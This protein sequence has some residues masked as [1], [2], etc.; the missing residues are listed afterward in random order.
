MQSQTVIINFTGGI[1]SPGYLK[2]ILDAAQAARVSH[3]RFGLRQQLIMEVPGHFY[4]TFR[5]VC[6]EKGIIAYKIKEALPNIV[7]SYPAADIFTTDSWMREGVYKDI[8]NSFHHVPQLKINICDGRQSF[9]PF[10][11]GHINWVSSQS[12]HFWHLYIRFPKT[13]NV[14]RWKEQVYTNDIPMLSHTIE[15]EILQEKDLYF[16][17]EKADGNTLFQRVKGSTSYIAKEAATESFPDFSLPYYEGFNKLNNQL[18]LGIYRRDEAF[19]VPFLADV[20]NLCTQT[21]IGQLYT[22]PW[23]SIIIKNIDSAQRK[24]WDIVLGRFRINVRHAAN[25]L[26]WQVE[27]YTDKGLQLKGQIIRY[28]DKEDVRTYGLCFAV[29]TKPTSSMFGSVVIRKQQ[30]KNPHRLKALER[31]D[32]LYKKDFN[33]NAEE[34][35]LFRD[36]VQKDH[37]GTYLVS[38]CKDFYERNSSS[39]ILENTATATEPESIAKTIQVIHQCKH[40]QTVYVQ[41]LGDEA[42]GIAPGTGFEMVPP[43]YSCPLCEAPKEA[44]VKVEEEVVG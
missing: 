30:N 43:H 42:Q 44:F 10:F 6:S 29:Q 2:E 23:K 14:Y 40:C 8:F 35:I 22:T 1:V 38:L 15:K 28:F 31:Y 39:T 19:P 13:G 32:I 3:V 25:E 17:N 20:C 33:P 11:T 4:E 41:A 16:G 37:I 26:A 12:Q 18:W 21:R 5:N 24:L 36:A 7:S 34:L 9:V 27:D